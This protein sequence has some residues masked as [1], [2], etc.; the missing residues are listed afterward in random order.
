MVQTILIDNLLRN[1][2]LWLTNPMPPSPH[3]NASGTLQT[4]C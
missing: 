2:V 4:A 3:T 1:R